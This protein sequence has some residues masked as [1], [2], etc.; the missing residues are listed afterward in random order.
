[1]EYS[2]IIPD[3][4]ISSD[5]IYAL[6]Y[7]AIAF[8][9]TYDGKKILYAPKEF[10]DS[11]NRI[12]DDELRNVVKRNTEWIQLTKGMLY[13]Y[14]VMSMIPLYN[15]L[16]KITQT[17]IIFTDFTRVI[18]SAI[19]FYDDFYHTYHGLVHHSV[20]DEVEIVEKRRVK[21]KLDY[22]D[23]NREQLLKASEEGYVERSNEVKSFKSFI[24]K[25][26]QITNEKIEDEIDGILHDI[27][28]GVELI[29]IFEGLSEKYEFPSIE[30]TQAFADNLLNLYNGSRQWVLKGHMPQELLDESSKYT[31]E[32]LTVRS[33][34]SVGVEV[35]TELKDEAQSAR[36]VKIGRNEPCP[37]GSGKKY[38][39][40][41]GN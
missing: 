16:C 13:Y 3:M 14:G 17:D 10:I 15:M 24:L 4:G 2:G 5:N 7:K 30:A 11:F 40:C 21:P 22:Y 31:K 27:K 25:H 20:V 8:P 36:R 12:N 28:S 34:N 19:D 18:F 37:C 9:G 41:C 1:A 38:K 26:Y 23:F 29:D 33:L 32:V 39:K 35:T 6:M